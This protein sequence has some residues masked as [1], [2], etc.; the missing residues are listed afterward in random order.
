MIYI[1]GTLIDGASVAEKYPSGSME[2]KILNIMLSS[3]HDY[4]YSSLSELEFELKLRKSI[5]STAI[6][7]YRSRFLF[8]VFRESKCNERYWE[9]TDEGGFL[10]KNGIKPSEAIKDI[11]INSSLYGTECATAMVIVFYG[12]VVNVFPE[13]VFDR[14]FSRIYLMDWMY[15]DRNLG[16]EYIREPEDYLP[17]DC[18]YF[19]NPDVDPLTPQWQGENVIDLSDGLYYGHGIGIGRDND[20]IN[21]LNKYRVSGS[22]TSAYLQR[23]ITRLDSKRLAIYVL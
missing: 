8:R 23:S 11:F 21:A 6:D 1:A 7:L 16:I 2:R 20:F 22:E 15:L 12:A 13:E 3:S 14:V 9:R 18:R 5:V 4:S 10:L 17:G 19:K